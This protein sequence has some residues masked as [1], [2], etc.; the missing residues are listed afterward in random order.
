MK[1]F[2]DKDTDIG[3]KLNLHKEKKGIAEKEQ[4]KVKSFIF[5][6]FFLTWFKIL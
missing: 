3:K 1:F 4:M 6:I 5:L 2:R